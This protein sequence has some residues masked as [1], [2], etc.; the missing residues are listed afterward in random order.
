MYSNMS[1]RAFGLRKHRI[2]REPGH[3]VLPE[4]RAEI[5][6][7]L[8]AQRLDSPH[9]RGRVNIVAFGQLARGKKGGLFAVPQNG[10]AQLL[11]MV[12]QEYKSGNR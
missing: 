11:G 7:T 3:E 4:I 1:N 2:G 12:N 8:V 5:S 6:E 9:H 10:A